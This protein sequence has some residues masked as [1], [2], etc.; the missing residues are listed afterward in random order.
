MTS[1]QSEGIGSATALIARLVSG[2]QAGTWQLA[3]DIVAGDY[4]RET[5][6]EL[7]GAGA[8]AL[9]LLADAWGVPVED[10][11]SMLAGDVAVRLCEEEN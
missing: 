1:P 9:Q 11:V 3:A 5:L 6:I 7:A 4:A 2:D 10:L 8:S